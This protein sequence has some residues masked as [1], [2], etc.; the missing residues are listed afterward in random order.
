MGRPEN[1]IPPDLAATANA[2]LA[3]RSRGEKPTQLEQRALHRVE[4]I[5]EEQARWEHYAAI[6][7]RHW[8]EM[9]GRQSKVINDQAARF[10][11]PF[12]GRTVNLPA[13]VRALHDF[14]ATHQRALLEAMEGAAARGDAL[15]R[16]RHEKYLSARIDRMVRERSLV[17][18][19]E[20]VGFLGRAA[21]TLKQASERLA[22]QHGPTAQAILTAALEQLE[23]EVARARTDFD[24]DGYVR[25]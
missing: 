16:M 14:F 25:G 6:P 9:S 2:A 19:A 24:A 7:H 11:I 23:R 18:R 13:V 15:E 22:Q 12:A 4:R 21:E 5:R 17:P 8:R 1:D 20:V 3:K 10:D